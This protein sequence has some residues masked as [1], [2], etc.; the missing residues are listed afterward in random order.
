VACFRPFRRDQDRPAKEV[1]GPAAEKG[2]RIV[3]WLFLWLV[4]CSTGLILYNISYEHV[5]PLLIHTMQ[6]RPAAWLIQ[7]MLGS[8]DVQAADTAILSGRV[9]LQILRGCDGIE[10]WIILVTALI[11][12][13][14]PWKHRLKGVLLGSLII[15][16]LNLVRIVSLFHIG[17]YK[18]A[19]FSLAHG[20]IWQSA[21]LVATVVFVLSWLQPDRF[22]AGWHL[23]ARSVGVFAVAAPV[24]LLLPEVWITPLAP[25]WS[26]LNDAGS[27]YLLLTTTRLEGPMLFGASQ[28]DLGMQV[29]DGKPIPLIPID[30]HY[31]T[32]PV[33]H[34]MLMAITAWAMP[35]M[36]F[37]SR[38]MSFPLV[39]MFAFVVSVCDLSIELH[40][41]VFKALSG[42]WLT[43][44]RVM[45]NEANR[46]ALARLQQWGWSIRSIKEFMNAGGRLFLGVMAGLMGC[47]VFYL[48]GRW[49]G[50]SGSSS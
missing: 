22:M 40:D 10:A 44:V 45:D 34:V 17:L 2:P 39:L 48:V 32:G 35:S 21:I 4:M 42:D 38:L 31:S 20:V 23:L 13:P 47:A 9:E 6:V 30:W 49:R 28:F 5:W 8:M 36:H 27:P 19:W 26:A 33:Q 7:S 29:G 41:Q 15:Y 18:P 3:R 37:R 12:F 24:V 11:G 46:D 50:S 14:A 1:Y 25:V 16:A 43:G